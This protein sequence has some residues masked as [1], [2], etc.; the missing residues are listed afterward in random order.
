MNLVDTLLISL[1]YWLVLIDLLCH[2]LCQWVYNSQQSTHARQ[3]GGSS[4]SV[5]PPPQILT[6]PDL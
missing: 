3:K 6:S 2:S 5:E 1:V 4:G